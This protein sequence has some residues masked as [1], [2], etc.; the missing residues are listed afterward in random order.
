MFRIMFALF[1]ALAVFS[2]ATFATE[3]VCDRPNEEYAC[4]SACQTT[5]ATL[6][7]TCPIVNIR[8]NDA[9]Y[10]IKGYARDC[11]GVCIP[12]ERCPGKRCYSYGKKKSDM[13]G[14]DWY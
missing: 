14:L 13:G 5:C 12:E 8:C 3:L 2:S 11:R 10:C 7:Q 6:G 4:G 1:V 9:C